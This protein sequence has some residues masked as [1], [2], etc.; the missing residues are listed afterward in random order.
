MRTRR[1]SRA[2]KRLIREATASLAL[3]DLPDRIAEARA[4]DEGQEGIAA[5]L[6]KRA[7][8]WSDSAGS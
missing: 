6:E 8:R 1:P 4:S 3:A 5:F 2:N 7:P